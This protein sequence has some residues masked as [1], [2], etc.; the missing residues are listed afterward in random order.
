MNLAG[1]RKAYD[2]AGALADELPYWGWL[3]GKPFCLTRRGE[4]VCIGALEPAIMDGKTPDQLDQVLHRWQRMLSQLPADETRFYFYFLRRPLTYEPAA[5]QPGD[6]GELAQ[7]R[8]REFLASRLQRIETYVAWCHDPGLRRAT[9]HA[10]GLLNAALAGPKSWLAKRRRPHEAAY[11]AEEIERAAGRFRQL[12]EASASLVDDITPIRILDAPDGNAVLS[13]L[14]NRPGT[15]SGGS[16]AGSA[17]NWRLALSELEAERRF[18]RLDGEPVVLYSLLSPPVRGR[19]NMLHDLFCLGIDHL[20]VS[21]EWRPRATA[22]SRRAIRKVQRAHF[23]KRYSAVSHM[24]ETDGTSSAMMDATAD[25]EAARIGLA[26]VE[27]EADGIAYGDISLTLALHG[28]L[29]EIEGRDAEIRRIFAGQ[30]AKLI[31]EGYGQIPAWF[32]RL[33]GQP[34]KRQLRTVLGS[35]GLMGSLAPLFGPASLPATSP[36]LGKP[37][38]A[39]FETPWRT[40]LPYD[41]YAG[42]GGDV[43]HTLILGATGSGKSFLVN[44]LLVQALQYDPRV[45]VLDLGGSYRWLTKF[46]NGGYIE[47]SPDNPDATLSLQPFSLPKSDRTLQFLTA[48]IIRLL[49]IGGYTIGGADTSEIRNRVEDLYAFPA[50]RRSLSLFVR[51]LPRPMWPAMSRWYGDGPWG[52]F[53]DNPQGDDDGLDL[54]DWQVID[55]AGAA[56]HEDLCEAALFYL[57]ERLRIAL[58]DPTEVGRVKLMVVDEAWRYLQDPAVLAYLAEAAK[59][60]RKRNAALVMATQSAVDVTGTPGAAAL[61]ES[62]PTKLFLANPDLPADV[63]DLFRLNDTEMSCIRG[64]QPKRELYLRR[65]GLAAVTRLQVD[66]QSYWLYTSSPHDAA[67]RQAAVEEHGLARALDILTKGAQP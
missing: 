46:L 61:I 4:L 33:P 10:P 20:T 25:E 26:L 13:E 60:W 39:L 7:A 57:L 1:E 21:M 17:V 45:L 41:L 42:G 9:R 40:A 2:A 49:K 51:S 6:V 64:L 29:Q 56:E 27:L 14:V 34:R 37:A 63:A 35:A 67:R 53:F 8:R 32:S 66:P 59:T 5:T 50:H 55:L 16:P 22:S 30:D 3:A 38:L 48:W 62:M 43:G 11:Y 18:L 47:L 28:D 52:R 15:P 31:R 65:S 36:H 24:Q 12:V 23:S 58:D 19:A 44:F 54:D